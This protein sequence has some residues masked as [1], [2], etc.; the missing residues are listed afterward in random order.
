MPRVITAKEVNELSGALRRSLKA[1]E[2]AKACQKKLWQDASGAA[3]RNAEAALDRV[4]RSYHDQVHE[5]TWQRE[6]GRVEKKLQEDCLE[7]K[8]YTMKTLEW[9]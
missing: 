1:G 8:D 6:W 3:Q 7:K 4:V 2:A 9:K 5:A